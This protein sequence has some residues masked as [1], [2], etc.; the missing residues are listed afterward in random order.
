MKR[1]APGAVAEVDLVAAGGVDDHE[2]GEPV[3][4][5]ITRDDIQGIDVAHTGGQREAPGTIA[6]VDPVKRWCGVGRALYGVSKRKIQQP[7][8]VE[9]R[10]AN[11][12][13]AAGSKA[14]QEA[15][16]AAAVIAIDAVRAIGVGK[17]EV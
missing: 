7:V 14:G 8:A 3:A 15:K 1:E 13:A 17:D 2:I 4:V 6:E 9:V 10:D 16:G 5:D 12:P 11:G